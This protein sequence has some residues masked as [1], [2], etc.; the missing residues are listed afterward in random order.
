MP[1]EHTKTCVKQTVIAPDPPPVSRGSHREYNAV[2]REVRNIIKKEKE[3][4]NHVYVN[5]GAGPQV[6]SSAAI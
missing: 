4:F 2:L 3:A 5:I 1:P 6:Y